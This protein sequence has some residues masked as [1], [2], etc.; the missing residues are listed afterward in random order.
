M[1]IT[2]SDS[3]MHSDG[4]SVAKYKPRC[5]ECDGV[6]KMYILHPAHRYNV[7]RACATRLGLKPVPMEVV[8]EVNDAPPA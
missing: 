6:D 4:H 7:C 3:S 1:P 2:T 8:D 5:W